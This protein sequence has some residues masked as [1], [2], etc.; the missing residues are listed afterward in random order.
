MSLDELA[1]SL[2]FAAVATGS[3][4]LDETVDAYFSM[5]HHVHPN[6]F[7]AAIKRCVISYP[8]FPKTAEIFAEL[9]N[10]PR[11][12]DPNLAS[13][14]RLAAEVK[15]LRTSGENERASELIEEFDR[16]LIRANTN[17]ARR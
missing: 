7:M 16:Q 10:V 15:R 8:H 6:R 13:A 9:R 1:E 17:A 4:L 11:S 12:I 14:N 5:F 3:E 2:A